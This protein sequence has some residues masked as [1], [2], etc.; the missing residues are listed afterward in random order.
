MTRNWT[1][2]QLAAITLRKKIYWYQLGREAVKP[3]LR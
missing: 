2:E 1:P 3:T